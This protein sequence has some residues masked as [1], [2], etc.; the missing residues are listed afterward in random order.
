M[1]VTCRHCHPLKRMKLDI[2]FEDVVEMCLIVRLRRKVNQTFKEDELRLRIANMNIK[3]LR[4]MLTWG[5]WGLISK[6]R[7][8]KLERITIQMVIWDS[9]R[10]VRPDLLFLYHLQNPN[11]LWSS[12]IIKFQPMTQSPKSLS[13]KFQYPFCQRIR[14]LS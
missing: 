11:P 4:P 1:I 6:Y 7:W 10:Q 13:F 2:N 3:A 5:N 9:T 8:P 12:K 14:I